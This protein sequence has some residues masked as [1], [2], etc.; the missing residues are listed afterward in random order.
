MSSA[1]HG[2][3]RFPGVSGPRRSAK[4]ATQGFRSRAPSMT[5][6]S[7]NPAIESIGCGSA[8]G[9]HCNHTPRGS[10]HTDQALPSMRRALFLHDAPAPSCRGR[11]RPAGGQSVRGGRARCRLAVLRESR[12]R[13]G[14]PLNRSVHRRR[15]A[16]GDASSS[17]P[18]TAT[19]TGPERGPCPEEKCHER[20]QYE[21]RARKR[22]PM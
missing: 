4:S 19:V 21:Y 3:V 7:R 2:A 13:R 9:S 1:R 17:E 20:D 11:H 12:A 18:G 6:V 10:V 22:K 16:P 14:E 8:T 15:G 5:R